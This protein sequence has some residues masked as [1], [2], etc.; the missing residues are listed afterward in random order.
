MTSL[1]TDDEVHAIAR[2][3]DDADIGELQEN[4]TLRFARA[5]E[6]AVLAKLTPVAWGLYGCSEGWTFHRT[7]PGNGTQ[8][9][10]L[11]E[12]PAIHALPRSTE[13]KE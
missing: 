3:V 8:L 5:V 9:Y 7:D 4:L 12:A 13:T 10:M 1:L 2:A 6:A 11:H